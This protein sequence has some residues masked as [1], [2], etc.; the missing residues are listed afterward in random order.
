MNIK[1]EIKMLY[2]DLN[3]VQYE[4]LSIMKKKLS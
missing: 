3:D 4:L 1:D 2:F